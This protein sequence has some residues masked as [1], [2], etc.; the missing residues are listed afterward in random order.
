MSS[1]EP[2][3]LL[4][5]G[6]LEGVS[7]LLARAPGS[8]S[9]ELGFA[10]PVKE[11]CRALG[12]AVAACQA[13]ATGSPEDREAADEAEVLRAREKLG[14]VDVLIVDSAG[15][16]EGAGEGDALSETLQSTWNLTRA[17]ANGAFIAGQAGGRVILLSPPSAPGAGHAT[18]AAAGLE[19]L[20]R[21]LSVEWARYGIT[22]VAIAPGRETGADEVASLSA[23]LA[24]PAGAYFSGCLMD[25]TG[26][27]A[28]GA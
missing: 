22:V 3:A 26:P 27:R 11:R 4:R 16:F 5:A 19:N 28:A 13:T 12:A 15:M 8:G 1:A 20:A 21:T 10:G 2:T 17:L 18:A 14:G 7:I 24:S 23:W 25:L 9:A 6:L